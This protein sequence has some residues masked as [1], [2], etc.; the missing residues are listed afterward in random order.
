MLLWFGV[1]LQQQDNYLSQWWCP[2]PFTQWAMTEVPL[3][4]SS[5]IV[6]AFLLLSIAL[7]GCPT[8]WPSIQPGNRFRIF[9][10]RNISERN[11]PIPLC[12]FP[13]L[14]ALGE[15]KLYL[16]CLVPGTSLAPSARLLNKQKDERQNEA[17]FVQWDHEEKHSL[18]TPPLSPEGLF[19]SKS[20]SCSQ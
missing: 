8:L 16:F 4:C 14:Q 18:V 7:Y 6:H 10:N 5:I 11:D 2:A 20:V 12:A 17:S 3:C 1:L 9:L 19:I 15:L 13:R